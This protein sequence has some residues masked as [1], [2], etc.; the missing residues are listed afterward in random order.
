MMDGNI[1]EQ[2]QCNYN[3]SG[4]I[5]PAITQIGTVNSCSLSW[6][7]GGYLVTLPNP[8][9]AARERRQCVTSSRESVKE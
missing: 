1:S 6:E 2:P 5:R 8:K 3:I 9:A 7:G 4:V